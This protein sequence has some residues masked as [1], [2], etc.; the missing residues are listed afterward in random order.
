MLPPSHST[1]RP[2]ARLAAF[3]LRVLSSPHETHS[4]DAAVGGYARLLR[5][6]NR[7]LGN[8]LRF[9]VFRKDGSSE[10]P[11]ITLRNRLGAGVPGS[12]HQLGST[13]STHLHGSV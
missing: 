3:P 9:H 13:G 7:M 5:V 12:T 8:I 11:D 10:G 4:F 6:L 1:A 2:T